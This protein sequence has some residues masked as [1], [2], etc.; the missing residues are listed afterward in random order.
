MQDSDLSSNISQSHFQSNPCFIY[1]MEA[2]LPTMLQTARQ[3]LKVAENYQEHHAISQ[4]L[5]FMGIAHYH[6]NELQAAEEILASVV[7]EPYSQYAWNFI[8]SAF[9]LALVHQARGRTDA[10]NQAGESVVS[11]GLDTNHPLVLKIAR[12]FQAELALRQGR[13]AEASYWAEQ[14]VAKPFT[15]MYRFYAPQ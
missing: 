9:A 2:D 11:Y 4:G 5:Y 14:F 12:A 7:N 3:S 6:Q 13:T 10:A 1:W 15:P 8:H